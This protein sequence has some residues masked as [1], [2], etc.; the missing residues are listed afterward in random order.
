MRAVPLLLYAGL[1]FVVAGGLAYP[2]WVAL[3]WLGLDAVPFHKLHFRLLE[4][5]AL[6][7]LFPLLRALGINDREHWGFGPGRGAAAG[8]SFGVG[9][10]RGFAA[11]V[12]ML[13]ALVA[14]LWI[15]GVRELRAALDPSPMF[16]A[17]AAGGALAGALV[18]GVVEEAWF[19][20]ALHGAVTRIWDTTAAVVA[21]AL[22]YAAVHFVR[23]DFR[24]EP[25]EVD[26]LSG[27][28]LASHLFDRM[29]NPAIVDSAL[30]LVAAGALLGL[31]RAHTGRIAECIGLHAGWV[32]V[33]K[34][35]RTGTVLNPHSG[36]S[37]LV[38]D[39]DGVLGWLACLVFAT[40][41]LVMWFLIRRAPRRVA[42]RRP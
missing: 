41:F 40:V 17:T 9:V 32:V 1:V 25:G 7:G 29:G 18:V 27:Y 8:A 36:W 3:A 20:G 42:A 24:I 28:V 15:L 26:W 33:I 12:V 14:V 10:A 30:A 34:L 35:T 38:G 4:L 22:V 5:C 31:V 19:R 11:G 16:L 39:Y 21:V 6:L 2:V 13:G 23:P 37:I